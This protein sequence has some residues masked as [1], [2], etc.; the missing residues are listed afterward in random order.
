MKMMKREDAKT[1]RELGS[2]AGMNL[3]P[4]RLGGSNFLLFKDPPHSSF[5]AKAG[6]LG[7]ST[8]LALGPRFHGDDQMFSSARMSV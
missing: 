6:I 4:S 7:L 5:P 2:H 3:V 1:P 8:S